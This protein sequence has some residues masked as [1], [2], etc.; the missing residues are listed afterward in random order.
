[1]L[2]TVTVPLI[3]SPPE[4]NVTVGAPILSLAV[5]V[6]VIVSS[7]FANDVELL[8]S[9]EILTLERVGSAVSTIKL[10]DVT[11]A[12]ALPAASLTSAV[13]VYV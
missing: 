9:D 13:S 7:A 6:N 2:F 8:L 1:M 5:K 3:A 4:R 10:D 11:C 12:A